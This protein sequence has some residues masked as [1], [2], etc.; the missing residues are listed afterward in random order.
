[1]H[2]RSTLA[3]WSGAGGGSLMSLYDAHRE[4]VLGAPVLHADETPVKMLDPGAGKTARAYVWAYARGE[5]DGTPG[6]M[7]E[8]CTGCGSK[9]PTQFLAEWRGTLTCAWAGVFL[10]TTA[11]LAPRCRSTWAER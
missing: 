4:F 7:Y 8:F 6:V 1:V 3:A 10:I 9:Y 11:V 5:H 2:R